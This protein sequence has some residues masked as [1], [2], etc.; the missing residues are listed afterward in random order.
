LG[1]QLLVF[2]KQRHDPDQPNRY[3]ASIT[4]D[5][6]VGRS[7]KQSLSDIQEKLTTQQVKQN[8]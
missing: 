4:Y 3:G 7:R 2:D 5:I 8:D 1:T 6:P